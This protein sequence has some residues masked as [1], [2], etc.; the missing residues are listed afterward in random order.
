MN[1]IIETSGDDSYF[2]I[3]SDEIFDAI[4]QGC[5]KDMGGASQ[6]L[7]KNDDGDLKDGVKT[8][9]TQW[10]VAEQVDLKNIKR[11]LTLP[12]F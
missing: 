2:S 1:L 8:F 9:S 11:I 3:V 12:M 10:G 5:E 4:L 6:H 7:Y